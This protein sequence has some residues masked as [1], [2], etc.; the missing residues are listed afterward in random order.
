MP[1]AGDNKPE[2]ASRGHVASDELDEQP[3]D[4]SREAMIL[5]AWKT[6]ST[7]RL[8][9]EIFGRRSLEQMVVLILMAHVIQ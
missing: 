9:G 7:P 1:H 2:V 6:R 3:I 8:V 4:Q 5:A